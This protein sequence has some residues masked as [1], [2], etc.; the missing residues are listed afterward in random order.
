MGWRI[1]K[2]AQKVKAILK[3]SLKEIVLKNKKK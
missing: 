2:L 3:S 1:E